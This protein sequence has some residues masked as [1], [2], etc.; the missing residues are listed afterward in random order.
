MAGLDG[1]GGANLL[2]VQDETGQD[3]PARVVKGDAKPITVPSGQPITL[4][5]II[6]NEPGPDGLTLRFRFLAPQIAAN[7]GTI[8]AQ[9]A[10]NDMQYLCD[11]FALPRISTLGPRPAQVV[12]SLSDVAVDFGE[13]APDATQ[14]FEAYAY[15]DGACIWEMY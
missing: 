5:D 15:R 12:I 10:L 6:W 3:A 1:A 4:Q 8:D 11:S 7:G 13:S 14:F 9:T 2:L